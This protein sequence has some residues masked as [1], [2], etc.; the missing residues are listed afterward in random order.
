MK[1]KLIDTILMQKKSAAHLAEVSA[2]APANIALCKYWG[3]RNVALHLPVNNSLSISLSHLGTTTKLAI[4]DDL[5][6]KIV[7][8]NQV[9]GKSSF[10]SQRLI[11]FLNMFRDKETHFLVETS[12]NLPIAAGLASSA[13]GFAAL[14]LCL[15]QLYRWDLSKKELSILARLGSGSAARSLWHGFVKWHAGDLNNGTDSYAEKLNIIWEEL[16][17]GI[18]VLDKKRKKI[19][20]SDAMAAT[21][22]QSNLYRSTWRNKAN[23]DCL[24]VEKA[25]REKN[26]ALLGSITQRNSIYMHQTMRDCSPPITYNTLATD[27]AIDKIL[28]LQEIHNIYFTQDAGPNIFLLFLKKDI[29]IVLKYFPSAIIVFPFKKSRRVYV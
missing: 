21:L 5:I 7:V 23:A 16:C 2:F 11:A 28:S 22:A 6:D 29:S 12:S 3:K 25:I 13:S 15:N 9:M 20:S 24:S 26:I 18:L 10:F 17:I 4:H 14:T 27:Q 19:S 8:N 1:K